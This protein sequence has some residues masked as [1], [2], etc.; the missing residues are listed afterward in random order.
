MTGNKT[1]IK[2]LSL[3]LLCLLG[4]RAQG[5]LPD[6]S[7]LVLTHSFTHSFI[8]HTFTEAW[9]HVLFMDTGDSDKHKTLMSQNKLLV[10]GRVDS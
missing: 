6:C 10:E 8:Q 7:I 3:R 1:E 2:S 9:S 4:R 5:A